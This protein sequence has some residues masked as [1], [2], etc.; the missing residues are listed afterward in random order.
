MLGLLLLIAPVILM[1]LYADG[2]SLSE[3]QIS[4]GLQ[5]VVLSFLGIACTTAF[6]YRTSI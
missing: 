3:I 6:Y 2:Y 1:Q 5:V 4:A